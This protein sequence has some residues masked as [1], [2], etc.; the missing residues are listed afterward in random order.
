M[1]KTHTRDDSLFY[2]D[3]E[4]TDTTKV[5]INA[6]REYSSHNSKQIYI[7]KKAL[8][9]S[10]EYS[11]EL[12]EIAIILMP[13]FPITILNYGSATAEELSDFQLASKLSED[14]IKQRARAFIEEV[15]GDGM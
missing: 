9:T 7:L 10:K 5:F 14:Q 11:Y 3:V 2:C 15:I 13:K 1:E 6:L 8:G 4:T 12:D